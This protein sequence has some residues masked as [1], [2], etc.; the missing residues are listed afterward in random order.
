[1]AHRCATCAR[2]IRV[3]E[4][5]K[6]T[7]DCGQSFHTACA[8]ERFI[9]DLTRPDSI[10]EFRCD[11]CAMHRSSITPRSPP[12]AYD[13]LAAD[14]Q[15]TSNITLDD[16]MRQLQLSTASTNDIK[17]QLQST[18]AAANSKLELIQGTLVGVKHDIVE[19]RS[20]ISHLASTQEALANRI[21]YLEQ[22][23]EN[24]K[25]ETAEMKRDNIQL[26]AQIADIS[27]RISRGDNT[28]PTSGLRQSAQFSECC[29][30]VIIS[31]VHLCVAESPLAIATTVFD[32]LGVSELVIDILSVRKM[33]RKSAVAG[34]SNLPDRNH[35]TKQSFVVSLKSARVRDFIIK[36]KREKKSLSVSDVFAID[37]PGF[38]FV[39]ELLPSDLFNLLLKTKAKAK[40][41]SYKYIWSNF[42]QILVRRDYGQPIIEINTEEDLSKLN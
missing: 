32:A 19:L 31:G 4:A 27:N 29:T 10:R 6:C 13:S 8:A 15:C 36:K 12:H 25:I 11:P 34:P 40:A 35:A 2:L 39:N 42:G 20:H 33:A 5:I 16:I 26:K 28:H 37:S 17:N 14:Q 9:Y 1:M 24:A 21:S 30:D 3:G 38:I 7:G 18:S 22:H 41:A 23:S